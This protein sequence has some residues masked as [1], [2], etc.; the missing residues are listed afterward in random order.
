MSPGRRPGR[1][2][3]GFLP[4]TTFTSASNKRLFAD[5]LEQDAG[6]DAG[7]LRENILIVAQHGRR[8]GEQNTLDAVRVF[9]QPVP[10]FDAAQREH[11]IVAQ[12]NGDHGRPQIMFQVLK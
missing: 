2:A 12:D 10:E 9:R 11:F 8:A 7:E 5:G 6:E 3:P 1:E 4:A